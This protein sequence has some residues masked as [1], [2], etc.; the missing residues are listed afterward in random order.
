LTNINKQGIVKV[1]VAGLV[2]VISVDRVVVGTRV[3][4][5]V[6]TPT[7]KYVD[8]HKPPQLE[9]TEGFQLRN[10]SKVKVPYFLTSVSQYSFS[11]T[12]WNLLQ[13]SIMPSRVG[14]GFAEPVS[15]GVGVAEVT[16]GRAHDQAIANLLGAKIHEAIKASRVY[17][18]EQ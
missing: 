11:R 17:K 10:S 16:E 2:L 1:D 4:A 12:K 15:V 18:E 9:P 6:S 3:V 5:A 7:Q 13:V 8:F 14:L